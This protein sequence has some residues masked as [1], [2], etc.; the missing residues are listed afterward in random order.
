[1]PDFVD[2]QAPKVKEQL[3]VQ[4]WAG[5]SSY[6]IVHAHGASRGTYGVPRIHAELRYAG[7]CVGP[8][9]VARLMRASELQGIRVRRPF[10]TTGVAH[11]VAPAPDLLERR[12]TAAA[13]NRIWVADITYGRTGE[14]W[15]FL[16][17][18]VDC[19]SRRIVGWSMAAH[20]RT[21]LVLDAVD[22]GT[23]RRRP[24]RGWCTNRT[25]GSSSPHSP[26]A[27]ACERQGSWP[28]WDGWATPTT[29]PWPIASSPRSGASC[30][31]GSAGPHGPPHEVPCSTT[32]RSSTT[33][34]GCTRRTVSSLPKN[35]KGDTVGGPV[36]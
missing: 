32:S 19:F 14:G 15:L 18:I 17:A 11:A 20:L 26:S 5:P 27:G 6:E 23:G 22:L 4:V 33:V 8:K 35:S 1:M 7:R 12:F 13:P 31:T 3:G 29:T 24:R 25:A 28:R 2:V 34:E 10:R 30:W 16:A 36:A 21:E 9:R